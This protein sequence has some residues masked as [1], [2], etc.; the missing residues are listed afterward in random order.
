MQM[1]PCYILV[2]ICVVFHFIS[3]LYEKSMF[4]VWGLQHLYTD[5][6]GIATYKGIPFMTSAGSCVS[7]IPKATIK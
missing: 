6:K 1:L 2:G 4:L 7:S 3:S 5:E